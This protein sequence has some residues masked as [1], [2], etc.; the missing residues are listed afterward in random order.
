MKIKI[1]DK[2]YETEEMSEEALAQLRSLQFTDSEIARNQMTLAA[3]QTSRNAYGR[4]LRNILEGTADTSKEDS[5]IDL[6][7]DLSFD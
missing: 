1:D 6:P 2:E 3:L 4:A 5:N 7:E